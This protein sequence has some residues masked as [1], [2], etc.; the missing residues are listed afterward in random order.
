[1]ES[2]DLSLAEEALGAIAGKAIE[3]DRRPRLP[4]HH[5]EHLLAV[6]DA[7]LKMHCAAP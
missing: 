5:G 2:I 1:M 3:R 6:T 4:V 7:W